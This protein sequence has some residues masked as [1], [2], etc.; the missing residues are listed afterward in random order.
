MFNEVNIVL[1]KE[2][3]SE[4]PKHLMNGGCGTTA[5]WK[6]SAYVHLLLGGKPQASCTPHSDLPGR[7][8]NLQFWSSMIYYYNYNG[9]QL[10]FH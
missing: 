10:P 2:V 8:K 4:K 5:G 3:L 6:T 9:N 1:C 7:V